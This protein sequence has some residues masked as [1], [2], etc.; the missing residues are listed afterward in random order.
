ML[1]GEGERNFAVL[2][3]DYESVFIPFSFIQPD[4][5]SG[6][7]LSLYENPESLIGNGGE[8]AGQ[9]LTAENIYKLTYTSSTPQLALLNYSGTPDSNPWNNWEGTEGYWLTYSAEEGV[10]SV[11]MA[12]SCKTDYIVFREGMMFSSILVC[13]REQ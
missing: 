3:I 13:T 9:G 10:L 1:Y 7:T 8:F 6:A 12:E 2:V 5:V 4:Y 11:E